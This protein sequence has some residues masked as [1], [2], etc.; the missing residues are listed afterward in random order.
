MEDGR[1]LDVT[2]V[3]WCTGFRA[4]FSWVALPVF[5]E[6]GEPEHHRGIAGLIGIAPGAVIAAEIPTVVAL[7]I[8]SVR[9]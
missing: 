4:G 9:R 6:S 3:I 2:N 7:T 1:R 5:G 8:A